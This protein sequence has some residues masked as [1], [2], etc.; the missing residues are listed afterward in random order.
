[1]VVEVLVE[2]PS[3]ESW[4][5]IVNCDKFGN[6]RWMSEGEFLKCSKLFV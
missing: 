6:V 2:N 5:F 1:M 4:K 3:V